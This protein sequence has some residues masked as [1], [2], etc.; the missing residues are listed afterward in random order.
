MNFLNFNLEQFSYRM[1]GMNVLRIDVSILLL[2]LLL[3]LMLLLL[4]LLLLSI[5]ILSSVKSAWVIGL[6]KVPPS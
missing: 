1:L 2:L 3:L 5:S 6:F 4:L